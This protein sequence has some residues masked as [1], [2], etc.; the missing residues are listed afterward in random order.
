MD[1]LRTALGVAALVTVAA[2]CNGG[3]ATGPLTEVE[4]RADATPTDTV[5][6]GGGWSGSGYL[7]AD[8]APQGGGG[9]WSGSGY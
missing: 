4:S 8:G 9:G 5:G 3:D 1:R 2:A 7:R 6:K